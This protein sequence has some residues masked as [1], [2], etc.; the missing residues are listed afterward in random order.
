M[1]SI[2]MDLVVNRITRSLFN[3]PDSQNITSKCNKQQKHS[4]RQS[5]YKQKIHELIKAGTSNMTKLVQK[6]YEDSEGA[7]MMK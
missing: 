4:Q 7:R 1:C 6:G 5:E 3:F 2:I